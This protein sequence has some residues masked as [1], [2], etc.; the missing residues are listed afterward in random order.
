MRDS[1]RSPQFHIGTAPNSVLAA[2]PSNALLLPHPSNSSSSSHSTLH[3]C[4]ASATRSETEHVEPSRPSS[5]VEF[6]ELSVLLF[7]SLKDVANADRIVVH[8]PVGSGAAVTV[9]D[10]LAHCG[11][12]HP[13]L[14]PWLPHVR[15]AVN[16]EY[17][18]LQQPLAASDEIAL[19]PPVS[20]GACR[21]L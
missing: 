11:R 16:C 10:F 2:A 14:A 12:Q 3:T 9:A 19:L 4:A 20:G 8:I 5:E 18:D 17:S 6:L 15:V 1:K 13:Q 21:F 7:A